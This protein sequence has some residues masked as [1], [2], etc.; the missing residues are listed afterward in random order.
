MWVTAQDGGFGS[1]SSDNG[2]TWTP[3]TYVQETGGVPDQP[4][5]NSI[6]QLSFGHTSLS[7]GL[8]ESPV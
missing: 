5:T 7:A 1:K 4:T 2:N 8:G 3:I 6:R